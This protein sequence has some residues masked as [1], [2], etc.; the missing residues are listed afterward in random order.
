MVVRSGWPAP[1]TLS[2]FDLARRRTDGTTA[3][4]CCLNP[5]AVPNTCVSGV[6][7]CA[8]RRVRSSLM[9]RSVPAQ[10][11]SFPSVNFSPFDWSDVSVR[12]ASLDG[13][14]GVLLLEGAR[15]LVGRGWTAAL[16]KRGSLSR[17]SGLLRRSCNFT[18]GR[19]SRIA[20]ARRFDCALFWPTFRRESGSPR[21]PRRG[22]NT[23]EPTQGA[24]HC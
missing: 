16:P 6:F 22:A 13:A 21:T 23:G 17:Q 19:Y 2:R 20:V 1:D 5:D 11:R 8:S 15:P 14:D 18:A 24:T 4:C 3:K 7:C 10:T 12:W 9:S